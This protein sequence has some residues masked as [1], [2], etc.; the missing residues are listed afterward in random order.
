MTTFSVRAVDLDG[1]RRQLLPGQIDLHLI[2][3]RFFL[4]KYTHKDISTV[5]GG[6]VPQT[7]INGQ[8]SCGN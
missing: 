2:Y 6:I 3:N 4:L 7:Q 8:T 1:E 5:V